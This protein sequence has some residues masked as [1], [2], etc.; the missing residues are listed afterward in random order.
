[1]PIGERVSYV[2]KDVL[3]LSQVA[4]AKRLGVSDRTVKR[5]E[6]SYIA[7]TR[8]NAEKI[9]ELAGLEPELFFPDAI[10]PDTDRTAEELSQI[11]AILAELRGQIDRILEREV[12]LASLVDKQMTLLEKQSRLLEAIEA[13]V[14]PPAGGAA[15][16]GPAQGRK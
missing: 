13:A 11:R 16:P 15:K 8:A 2:R 3:R 1:L 6:T 5:W 12:G 9:A 4:F 7:P 10:E 14:D